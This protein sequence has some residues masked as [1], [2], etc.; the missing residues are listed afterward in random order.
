MFSF[1]DVVFG[2]ITL[3]FVVRGLFRGLLKE[4]LSTLGMI[5]AWW[6]GGKYGSVVADALG[7]WFDSRGLAELVGYLV[8]FFAVMAVV[9]F[10]TWVLAKIL[11]ASPAAWIDMPGGVLVGLAKAW[12]L[13]CIVLAGLLAYLPDAGFIKSSVLVPYLRPGAEYLQK[14]MPEGMKDF[15]P[16][17]MMPGSGESGGKES[18]NE[19]D[20]T[21]KAKELLE[22]LGNLKEL[23]KDNNDK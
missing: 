23:T 13:C 22:K 2:V 8:V 15:D 3:I 14:K 11:K 16:A 19:A 4:I 7:S 17:K 6:L 18:D 12:L 1:L 20:M 5:G 21:R 10:L 9:K